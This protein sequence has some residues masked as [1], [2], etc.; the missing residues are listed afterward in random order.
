MAVIRS[1]SPTYLTLILMETFSLGEFVGEVLVLWFC[2]F[3][4]CPGRKVCPRHLFLPIPSP[5][6]HSF[7][8]NLH[9]WN[10]NHP[11]S[12]SR[13]CC[14]VFSRYPSP[15]L[16]YQFVDL[17]IEEVHLGWLNLINS[18]PRFAPSVSLGK[19]ECFLMLLE[20]LS[21]LFLVILTKRFSM[22]IKTFPNIN[23]RQVSFNCLVF[24]VHFF[25]LEILPRIVF[26][27]LLQLSLHSVHTWI[28]L[29]F[30]ETVNIL[31]VLLW[32]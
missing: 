5:F 30:A 18:Q 23:I 16:L 20:F 19:A 17:K 15:Y 24:S 25:V 14:P 21:F 26:F 8:P 32:G 7:Q 13:L 10:L 27:L 22:L 3:R 4:L 2:P 31:Y 1:T 11:S 6:H 9:P 12:S 29:D 28:W